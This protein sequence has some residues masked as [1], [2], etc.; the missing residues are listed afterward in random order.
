MSANTWSNPSILQ[1]FVEKYAVLSDTRANTISSD[2]DK[3]SFN[4]FSFHNPQCL[5]YRERGCGE[6]LL[7][8]ALK[9][10]PNSHE[11]LLEPSSFVCKMFYHKR[12]SDIYNKTKVLA[13]VHKSQNLRIRYVKCISLSV[14]SRVD[15]IEPFQL[16]AFL[17]SS[18]GISYIRAGLHTQHRLRPI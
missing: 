6:P 2:Q 13:K 16:I 3:R 5:T 1:S 4:T 17:V 10:Q 9:K 8:L 12:A 14:K 11:I 18:R 15:V 7:L